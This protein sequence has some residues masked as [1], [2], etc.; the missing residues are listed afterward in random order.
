MILFLKRVSA[1]IIKVKIERCDHPGLGG[2]KSNDEMMSVLIRER[3]ED[4]GREGKPHEGGGR[5]GCT[6]KP[7]SIRASE[8]MEPRGRHGATGRDQPC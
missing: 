4:R 6:Y 5:D 1:D 2:P 3:R 7:G 8:T